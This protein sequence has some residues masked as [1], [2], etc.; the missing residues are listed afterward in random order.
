VTA[1]E[2]HPYPVAPARG[3]DPA[4]RRA[5]AR[6]AAHTRWAREGDRVAATQAAR[7]GLVKRFEDEVDPGRVLDP[8]ERAVRVESAKRA[9]FTRL[10]MK[11]AA[12]RA[13]K[14]RK[15]A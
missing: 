1:Q 3:G 2:E 10:A 15:S 8:A 5:A 7:D 6:V 13:A 11:S 9:F 14:K 12:S 4:V